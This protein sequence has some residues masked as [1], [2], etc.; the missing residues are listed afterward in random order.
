[1]GINS[2]ASW[3][4]KFPGSNKTS[5]LTPAFRANFEAFQKAMEDAGIDVKVNATLRP[6][7]RAY[8]MHF[9]WMIVKGQIKPADVP[10]MAGVDI[11][12]DHA[13]ALAGAQEMVDAYGTGGSLVAPALN[14]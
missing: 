6:K 5:D 9:S 12:W 1:M 4:S 3:V 11:I 13:H 7:E 14:S 10:A 2:G 8:L